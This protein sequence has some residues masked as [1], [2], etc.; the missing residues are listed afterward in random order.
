MSLTKCII[1]IIII[2]NIVIVIVIVLSPLTLWWLCHGIDSKGHCDDRYTCY[3][4]QSDFTRLIHLTPWA[5][6]MAQLAADPTNRL[7]SCQKSPDV[8]V[9]YV[10]NCHVTAITNHVTPRESTEHAPTRADFLQCDRSRFLRPTFAIIS[11]KIPSTTIISCRTLWR[12]PSDTGMGMG[13]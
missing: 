12:F 6:S 2:I 1:I 11:R 13:C 10:N 9:I 5:P 3:H 4:I 8:L 7:L